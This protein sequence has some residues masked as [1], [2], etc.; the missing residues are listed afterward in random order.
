MSEFLWN[1]FV[2]HMGEKRR[3][4]RSDMESPAA[5]ARGG[6]THATVYVRTVV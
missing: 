5:P 1:H 6:E 3:D 4:Y 2:I